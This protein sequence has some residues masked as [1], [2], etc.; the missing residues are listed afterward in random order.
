M[1]KYTPLIT[2]KEKNKN[3][4]TISCCLSFPFY[5]F[6]VIFLFLFLCFLTQKFL[7]NVRNFL[8]A[9]VTHGLTNSS[10]P[11]HVCVR[12]IFK[13]ILCKFQLSDAVPWASTQ[14]AL[15]SFISMMNFFLQEPQLQIF[16]AKQTQVKIKL[17]VEFSLNQGTSEEKKNQ[18]KTNN[19]M[20]FNLLTVVY[21]KHSTQLWQHYC[22]D[23]GHC[24]TSNTK[25]LL[26][27]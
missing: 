19:V 12:D 5:L 10:G 13:K 2:R 6:S 24:V 3:P 25:M 8:S 16:W 14:R 1:Y 4:P 17:R 22:Q 18:D 23:P 20:S 26:K 9:W 7:A 11:G 15:H 27:F 21:F